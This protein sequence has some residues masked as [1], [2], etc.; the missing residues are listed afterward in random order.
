MSPMTLKAIM[1]LTSASTVLLNL[2][3]ITAQF[4]KIQERCIFMDIIYVQ[5]DI[6]NINTALK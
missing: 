1:P 2:P 4:L 3:K 5:K 6:K